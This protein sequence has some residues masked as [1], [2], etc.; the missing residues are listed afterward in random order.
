LSTCVQIGRNFRLW[1]TRQFSRLRRQQQH[2]ARVRFR[3][4]A[5]Y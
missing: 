4:L 3:N 5:V 1:F 2:M